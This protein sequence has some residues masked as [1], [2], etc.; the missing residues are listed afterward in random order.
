MNIYT[1][2]QAHRLPFAFPF[3]YEECVESRTRRMRRLTAK[4]KAAGRRR[5]C[6]PLESRRVLRFKMTQFLVALCRSHDMHMI[7]LF[8]ISSLFECQRDEIWVKILDGIYEYGVY[9][10][11]Q[12]VAS[13]G[14]VLLETLSK[15]LLSVQNKASCQASMVL[16]GN[17]QSL[18]TIVY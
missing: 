18:D 4:A 8:R 7:G 10:Y 13:R 11:F 17:T 6:R 3:V 12:Q 1:Y 14:G 5:R 2:S 9:I 15:A 16:P